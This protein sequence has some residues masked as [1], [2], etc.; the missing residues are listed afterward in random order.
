MQLSLGHSR[1]KY[2]RDLQSGLWDSHPFYF[3]TM[4]N[5]Q[6]HSSVWVN[7]LW[8]THSMYDPQSTLITVPSW[9]L[10]SECLGAMLG[11]WGYEVR[12]LWDA[13]STGKEESSG[14][15][16]S[17]SPASSRLFCMFS[18]QLSGSHSFSQCPHLRSEQLVKS[19]LP[20]FTYWRKF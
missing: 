2:G 18:F 13:T 10:A 17:M 11:F 6:Q 4:T 5:S 20:E 3:S 7:V 8:L 12:Q 9:T 19:Q 1:L 14:Y 16:D 15:R